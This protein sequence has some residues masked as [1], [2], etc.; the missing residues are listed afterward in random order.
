[1]VDSFFVCLFKGNFFLFFFFWLNLSIKVTYHQ[2][3]CISSG[4]RPVFL[5]R[6]HEVIPSVIPNSVS[7]QQT[8]LCPTH[9]AAVCAAQNL[10]IL[11]NKKNAKQHQYLICQEKKWEKTTEQRGQPNSEGGWISTLYHTH[12]IQHRNKSSLGA[13]ETSPQSSPGSQQ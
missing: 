4:W 9:P 11:V 12:Y 1:M 6:I 8:L 10:F 3:L 13:Q 7:K 5:G 2:R